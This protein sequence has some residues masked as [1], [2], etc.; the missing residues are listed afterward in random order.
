MIALTLSVNAATCNQYTNQLEKEVSKATYY[1]ELYLDYVGAGVSTYSD[2]S[3]ASESV[4]RAVDLGKYV[5]ANCN[6]DLTYSRA[7]MWEI[8]RALGLNYK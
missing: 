8:I 5:K 6:Y 1:A 2:L 4:R 7:Q 3:K